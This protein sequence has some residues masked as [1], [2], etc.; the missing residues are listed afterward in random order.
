M[1]SRR[2]QGPDGP[3]GSSRD[4]E[5]STGEHGSLV[6]QISNTCNV[7]CLCM[8]RFDPIFESIVHKCGYVSS[9][10][11]TGVTVVCVMMVDH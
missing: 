8:W 5:A 7:F 1:V 6:C 10:C 3:T 4:K 9:L 2:R 11:A